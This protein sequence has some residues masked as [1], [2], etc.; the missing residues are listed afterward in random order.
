MKKCFEPPSFSPLL[1][2]EQTFVI[3]FTPSRIP[4]SFSVSPACLRAGTSWKRAHLSSLSLSLR[5]PC[6]C[7]DGGKSCQDNLSC[8]FVFVC[9]CLS[10]CEHPVNSAT[11]A[12]KLH[13]RSETRVTWHTHTP[14]H[15]SCSD[16]PAQVCLHT[17]ERTFSHFV[18]AS[19]ALCCSYGNAGTFRMKR[20][21]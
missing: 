11:R 7:D 17:L 20:A 10:M 3:V 9:V 13:F 14:T 15:T 4:I 18:L 8:V 19:V 1:F 6:C 12:L 5:S 16:T 21:L 2:A